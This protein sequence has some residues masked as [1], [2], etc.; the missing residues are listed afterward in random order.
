MYKASVG[1]VLET[2]IQG[3]SGEEQVEVV[4]GL[5]KYLINQGIVA[6]AALDCF[7]SWSG[8]GR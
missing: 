5:T 7:S 6:E 8:V 3:L 1:G 2:V 4:R